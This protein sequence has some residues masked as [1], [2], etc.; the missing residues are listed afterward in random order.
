VLADHDAGWSDPD[1][2]SATARGLQRALQ[3]RREQNLS[4]P[5]MLESLSSFPDDI[6]LDAAPVA[7]PEMDARTHA[8]MLETGSTWPLDRPP[9]VIE[10]RIAD[11][12]GPPGAMMWRRFAEV[13]GELTQRLTENGVEPPEDSVERDALALAAPRDKAAGFEDVAAREA[14]EPI[15]TPPRPAPIVA[16]DDDP[17]PTLR[18]LHGLWIDRVHPGRKAIDDNLL[19]VERFFAMHGDLPADKIKRKHV[20]AF[21][22]LLAK[23]PRVQP[24]ELDG[25]TPEEIA[26]WAEARPDP[27]KL[28][29]MTINAK[30]I[31]AISTSC[32]VRDGGSI[33]NLS[34]FAE[35]PAEAPIAQKIG[36]NRDRER[37]IFDH[38]TGKGAWPS[39]FQHAV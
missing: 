12:E 1:N 33:A 20:R 4:D 6:S 36:L 2:L 15:E 16:A 35:R 30:G 11:A 39:V 23:F 14:G 34:V 27:S 22:D 31:G 26:A 10:G 3:T 24:D 9:A 29:P 13:S 38:L 18:G 28:T 17:V 19:Y 21:C 25:K 32:R 37:V 7:A 8:G 5:E